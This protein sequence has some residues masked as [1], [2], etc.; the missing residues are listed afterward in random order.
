N[1]FFEYHPNEQVDFI[2]FHWNHLNTKKREV[3]GLK[4]NKNKKVWE[5]SIFPIPDVVFIQGYLN[6][7][8]VKYLEDVFG[9][10]I[11][12]NFLF[13]KWEGWK[14]LS[15]SRGLKEYL[16]NTQKLKIDYLQSQLSLYSDYLIKPIIGSSGNGI[17]RIKSFKNGGFKVFHSFKNEIT[18]QTFASLYELCKWV[19]PKIQIGDYILQKRVN[20]ITYRRHTCDIRLNMNKNSKG[21][22]EESLVLLRIASNSN[23]V[24]PTKMSRFYTIKQLYKYPLFPKVNM[25]ELEKSIISLGHKICKAFDQ[26]GY[27][28]A[29]LGI[30]L[31]LDKKGRLWIFEVNHIPYPALSFVEDLSIIRPFE[32]ALF[33]A[34]S[35]NGSTT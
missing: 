34:N 21:N 18:Y 12:N 14:F 26:S 10:N 22:W 33:L 9:K 6:T 23:F 1:K 29:D 16:P 32:Y 19:K 5:N 31:G 11:F 35:T 30:D 3:I 20:T 25:K 4:F 8:I 2:C 24:I 13:D 27:H 15:S 28:M 17:M 7:K